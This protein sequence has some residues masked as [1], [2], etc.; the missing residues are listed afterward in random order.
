MKIS[1]FLSYPKP[2]L[3][4]QQ[5]FI[6]KVKEYLDA[7][8]IETRT[9]GVT[10]YNMQEP[11]VGIRRILNESNGL[12]AIAFRRTHIEKACEKPN[13]DVDGMDE[14][15]INNKWLTSAYCQ[16][17]PA[18]AFQIGLPILIFREKGVIADGIL[19][20][21]VAGIYLPEFNLD[22]DIDEY[23]QSEEWKQVI[24]DWEQC[25]GNVY[26]AKGYPPKLY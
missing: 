26:K 15:D 5:E 19:E 11:L 25:V 9:I 24:R 13:T 6:N 3:K 2:Y 14:K 8:G 16:I 10:D 4:K 1:V 21:G 18:M 17:E 7:R 22:Y 23:F 20:K 12:L